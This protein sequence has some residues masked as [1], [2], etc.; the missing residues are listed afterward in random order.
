MP[1]TP[2]SQTGFIARRLLERVARRPSL[3][4]PEGDSAPGVLLLSDIERFTALVEAFST[5]GREGLEELTWIL[6]AYFADVADTVH[7]HG[8]DI[9]SIAGDAFLCHWA[10]TAESLPH[11]VVRATQ[12]GLALQDRLHDR[13][14][15]AGV[16]IRTRIGIGAG[17]LVTAFAGGAGGRWELVVSGPALGAAIAAEALATPGNLT[18]DPV[19]AAAAAGAIEG[20]EGQHG[21]VVVRGVVRRVEPQPLGAVP[22]LPDELLRPLLPPAVVD[23]IHLPDT[24]WL[25]ESRRVTVLLSS[26]PPLTDASDAS[27]GRAHAGVRAF[28]EVVE[29]YDGTIKVDVDAKGILLLAIFGLPPR[30]HEDDAERAALAGRDLAGALGKI[31]AATGIGIATGRVLCGAFGSDARRDYMVRGEAINLAA[32]LMQHAKAGEILC[33]ATTVTATRGRM[34]FAEAGVV[35]VKGRTEPVRSF[36]PVQRREAAVRISG[37][38]VG[39]AT[40]RAAM[41]ERVAALRE[42]GGSSTVVVEAEAGLG[43]SRLLADTIAVASGAGLAVLQAAAD[44]IEQSTPFYAWR[45]VF[46]RIFELAPGIDPSE[47]RQR[48]LRRLTRLPDV[49]HLAPLLGSVVPFPMPDNEHTADMPGEVRAANTRRL[50]MAML[51]DAAATNRTMLAVEDAHW[52]DASSFELLAEAVSITPL[53]TVVTTRPITE[54]PAAFTRIMGMPGTR[55]LRLAGLSPDEMAVLIA[56]RLTT[57]A[58]PDRLV[59]F[60]QERVSG[61]PFFAEELLQSMVERGAVRVDPDGCHVGDLNS[62]DLPTTVE[63]VIVSRLDRLTPAE[64]LCLKVASVIGRVFRERILQQAHPAEVERDRVPAHLTSLTATDLIGLETPEPDLAY[65]FR[66]VITRDVTY[67]T[68]P[69]AQRRPLHRAVAEWYESHNDDL[70]PHLALLAYHWG[71]AAD[72][73]KTV[74]YLELAGNKA[75]RD[76]AFRE[77]IVFLTQAIELME[78]G[79][80]PDDR[81]RRALWHKSIGIALYFMNDMQACREHLSKALARLH[82]PVPA[83]TGSATSGALRAVGRQVAH[84]VAPRRF[85]G[86]RGHEKDVLDHAVECY[87]FLGNAFYMEG[88]EPAWLVYSTVNGLNLGELA[89]PSPSFARI[90]GNSAML[91]YIIGLAGRASHYEQRAI[92]M[93]ERVNDRSARGDVLALR[94]LL[95]AQQARWREMR[96]VNDEAAILARE[97]NDPGLESHIWLIRSTVE[98]CSGDFVNAPAAWQMMRELATRNGNESLRAWSLLDEVETRLARGELAEAQQALDAALAIETPESDQMTTLEKHRGV[99]GV[100][101]REGRLAE[102]VDAANAMY[103]LIVKAPPTG[104]HSADHFATA[105]DIFLTALAAPD[106]LAAATVDVLRQR[107]E[108]G[109]SLVAKHSRTYVNVRARSWTLRGLLNAQR[110]RVPKAR[111]CF[112]RAAAIGAQLETPFERARALLELSRLD[113]SNGASARDEARRLF[114]AT[115]APWWASMVG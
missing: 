41:A 4:G 102:A 33:D 20:V 105:V 77:G 114:E 103:D 82:Q 60:I 2:H 12:C 91:A 113:P 71:Q 8:G 108:K 55:H 48:V 76:G 90:L 14:A 19:A 89:G 38:M 80:I 18:I 79:A 3:T 64:Q 93:L 24:Q 78:G 6:N 26:L 35:S 62:L 68:M 81:I 96:A 46:R 104:Y 39:R 16:P 40:E 36:H 47:G 74:H 25:A 101:V 5:S 70:T 59:T 37:D 73:V 106:S 94:S 87:R 95:Y 49:A 84:S 15:R 75:V 10:A 112:E 69:L 22:G 88:A 58:V 109:V 29:R 51:R 27:I 31:G 72:P 83:S 63:Q 23:R 13:Q 30:A 44:A 92:A 111:R 43:K 21:C 28:Q 17:Y 50:L 107:A 1:D 57:D 100:R 85:H 56:R 115:G 11:V 32:R 42:H 86:R 45:P 99:A 53:L 7:A 66:H 9:L 65:L 61:H 97:L 67:D 34:E 52:L 110:G 54:A 98:H